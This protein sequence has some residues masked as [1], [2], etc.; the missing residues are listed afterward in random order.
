ME[1]SNEISSIEEGCFYGC[2]ALEEVSLPTF[3]E[4]IGSK[5]FYGCINLKTFIINKTDKMVEL[6]NVDAFV[7]VS[8]E[9]RI[10]VSS[11][12]IDLYLQYANWKILN[13]VVF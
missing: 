10:V 11:E 1:L 13:L 8:L 9:H 6:E 4:R 5:A 12:L 3:V 2:E 7:D